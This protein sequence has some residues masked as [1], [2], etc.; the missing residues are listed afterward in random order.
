MASWSFS[1]Q[2]IQMTSSIEALTTG[3]LSA[4]LDG[5]SRRH[6]AVAAN[7]ANANTEGYVPVRV[8]FDARLEDARA[9][10]TEKRGLDASMLDALRGTPEAVLDAAG[11][12]PKVELDLEMAEL[13]RNSVQYQTLTQALSRHLAM[14]ALAA[15][16][17]RK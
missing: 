16:D 15:A 2:E 4:A 6:A 5:A 10:L 1:E 17:G 9:A 3:A 7:I 13:A 14:L 11:Q 8:S 12:P